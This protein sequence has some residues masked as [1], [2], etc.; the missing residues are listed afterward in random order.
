MS[1]S[2]T[3][4]GW[5]GKSA[6]MMH[7]M[8]KG[9]ETGK[10]IDA[11]ELRCQKREMLQDII[12][13]PV[14]FVV[15]IEPTNLC[16]FC[17]SFCPTGDKELLTRVHRPA[18]SMDLDLFRKIVD[19]LK[20]FD[21]KLRL[22][23]LY[24]DGEPLLHK[25]FPEMVQYIKQADVAERIWT[26]TNG[27]L[28]RPELNERLIAAGLDMICISV[29]GLSAEGY[30]RITG[31]AVDYHA[32]KANVRDLHARRG[33]CEIYIKIADY[34]LT[35]EDVAQFY[36]DFQPFSTYISVEKLMGWSYSSLKDF[37]LGTNPDT[38]DG[39]PLTSK[40]VCPYPFYVMAVNFN[41]T[42]SLCG[43]DWSH[44]TIVGDVTRDS[45]QSIWNGERMFQFRSMM[46]EGRRREN[47]ACGDCYYLKIVPDN[48]DEHRTRIL[49]NLFRKRSAG[50]EG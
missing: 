43:N 33:N 27:S 38:Y 21:V 15:Y 9:S 39:L 29:D 19:D 11:K 18:G 5:G 26:K 32:F 1:F 41:G 8:K 35:P 46:L 31:V 42:V 34:G 20:A 36:A 4:G 50:R 22:A 6:F 47:R 2:S 24:K 10:R 12:P 3:A 16:N 30:K 13:L 40:D 49:E 28:L 37:T 7:G 14:P 44:S 25:Q 48:I 23:S 17:C 45:L